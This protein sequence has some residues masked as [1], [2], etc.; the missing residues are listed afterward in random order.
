MET[1][2]SIADWINATFGPAASNLRDATRAN[3]EMAEL[4]E[5]FMQDA[6]HP[7]VPEEAADVA[8]V[9]CRL[10]AKSGATIDQSPAQNLGGIAEANRAMA[11]LLKALAADDGHPKV[12]GM[13]EA[14]V[15]PLCLLLR[16]HKTT[17]W[18]QVQKKMAV[19]RSRVWKRDGT[20]C[21]YH[22]K[23]GS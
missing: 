7:K 11:A 13:V 22:V 5:A 16:W 10:A 8:I 1:T 9:L 15:A 14:V 17:L 19:N 2:Q 18:E 21:G 20:G 4:V 12:A 3:E 23:E 6:M